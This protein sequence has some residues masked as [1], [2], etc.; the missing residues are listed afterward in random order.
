[1]RIATWYNWLGLIGGSLVVVATRWIYK[2]QYLFHWDSVQFALALDKIDIIGHRPHPPGYVFYIWIAKLFNQFVQDDNTALILVGICFSIIGL[3][4]VFYF[5][6][7]V[8]KSALAGWIA[9]LLF[10]VNA[11]IWF[12]GLVAEVYLVEAVVALSVIFVLYWAWQNPKPERLILAAGLLGLVGGF[13]QT[14]ELVL[15]PLLVYVLIST[16]TAFKYWFYS[17]VALILANLL[18]LIPVTINTGGLTRYYDAVAQLASVVFVFDY[19][20]LGLWGKIVKNLKLQ[21][22][23]FRMAILAELVVLYL[24]ASPYLMRGA[25]K[26]YQVNRLKV[27]FW[28]LAILPALLFMVMTLVTNAGYLMIVILPT[29]VLVSGGLVSLLN[30]LTKRWRPIYAQTLLGILL[31]AVSSYQVYNF[32]NIR[33]EKFEFISA[34]LPSIKQHDVLLNDI[35]T[36]IQN[37]GTSQNSAVWINTEHTLLFFGIRH[38]QYYL[39]DFDI[40]RWTPQS[41]IQDVGQEIWHVR[42][43]MVDQFEPQISIGSQVKKLFSLRDNWGPMHRKYEIPITLPSGNTMVYYDLTDEDTRQYL[44]KEYD[45]AFREST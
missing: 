39:P 7:F 10:I 13:R 3:W 41:F 14:T 22:D 35:I 24:A 45:F 33:P 28:V 43:P 40:Y 38:L 32:Y 30:H 11:S 1:M 12:H 44:Q 9:A 18:W 31:L 8:F 2:S 6:K 16:R 36:T 20:R 5:A 27:W 29:I 4:V 26:T 21:I 42:G 15:L 34:S 25:G 23:V 17:G 37:N 19:Y